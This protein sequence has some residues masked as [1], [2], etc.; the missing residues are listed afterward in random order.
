MQLDFSIHLVK[1]ELSHFLSAER[2]WLKKS[3]NC[4]ICFWLIVQKSFRKWRIWL[5]NFSVPIKLSRWQPEFLIPSICINKE[6]N[7][8]KHPQ[9]DFSKE[10]KIRSLLVCNPYWNL[11]SHIISNVLDHMANQIKSIDEL[12]MQWTLEKW[13]Y[14]GVSVD[15][16]I[17]FPRNDVAWSLLWLIPTVIAISKSN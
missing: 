2:C 14:D 10:W 17:L 7:K 3:V 12:L 13:I 8:E 9:K 1:R 11:L 4:A 5:H 16:E 6:Y 15:Y